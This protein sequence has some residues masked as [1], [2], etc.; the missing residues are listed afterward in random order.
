M[1]PA[2]VRQGLQLMRNYYAKDGQPRMLNDAQWGVYI[3]GLMPFTPADLERA[4]NQ[5]MQTSQFFPML[6]ELLA[7]LRPPVDLK[8]AAAIAWGVVEK[9]IRQAGSY[10]GVTF[11]QGVIGECVRQV[12]GTWQRACAFE[13]DSPG[14]AIRRQSFMAVFPEVA[15]HEHGPVTLNGL[16]GHGYPMLIGAVPGVPAPALPLPDGSQVMSRADAKTTLAEIQKMW[17]AK[18]LGDGGEQGAA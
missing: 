17:N 8:A 1:T 11:E 9:A 10:Q 13:F 18:R 3:A 2:E 12:F 16:Q 7:I 4:T 15:R 14:W 6:S 5:W